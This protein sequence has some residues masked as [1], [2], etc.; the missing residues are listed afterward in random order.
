M[1]H[2]HL[3]CIYFPPSLLRRDHREGL[4]TSALQDKWPTSATMPHWTYYLR[5]QTIT[6]AHTHGKHT[7][8][9]TWTALNGLPRPDL[10]VTTMITPKSPNGIWL[11]NVCALCVCSHHA[12]LLHL[13]RVFAC[14]SLHVC[15]LECVCAYRWH[16]E[17]CHEEPIHRQKGR[18]APRVW[19]SVRYWLSLRFLIRRCLG[20]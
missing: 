5:H 16:Q 2:K 10:L 19:P 7:K 8:A 6:S 14:V 1:P 12:C 20:D 15:V 13:C 18:C 9:V 4:W 11:G 17:Q 3:A